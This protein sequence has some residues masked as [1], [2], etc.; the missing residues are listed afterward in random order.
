M[1]NALLWCEL[2]ETKELGSGQIIPLN[3]IPVFPFRVNHML[4]QREMFEFTHK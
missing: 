3:D 4:M 1:I 2:V